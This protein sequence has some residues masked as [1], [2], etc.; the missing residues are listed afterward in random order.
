MLLLSSIEN[1]SQIRM[2]VS[3][4]E[5]GSGNIFIGYTNPRGTASQRIEPQ[6]PLVHG[7]DVVCVHRTS[8]KGI[9]V[10]SPKI[11]CQNLGRY[12]TPYG[13]RGCDKFHKVMR[14]VM[15]GHLV[16]DRLHGRRASLCEES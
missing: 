13:R 3:I 11:C 7:F 4:E 15:Q 12:I 1:T 14:A 16:L 8:S 9:T 2:L 5:S 6:E 10:M